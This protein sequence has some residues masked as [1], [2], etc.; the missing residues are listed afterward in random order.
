MKR[1][2]LLFLGISAAS[3]LLLS[4]YL[5]LYE[6]SYT[7][8]INVKKDQVLFFAHRGF[9]NHAPDNSLVG[10]RLALE[11]GLDGV[12]VD[13]QFSKDKKT[14]IFHDVSLERFTIGEGRVDG[15]SVLWTKSLP[16]V[17]GSC[18]RVRVQEDT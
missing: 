10:A 9:G 7:G 3:L 17:D 8:S 11:R 18:F 13:A 16:N 4:A 1:K 12:D 5:F 6:P 2:L 15:L 14:F